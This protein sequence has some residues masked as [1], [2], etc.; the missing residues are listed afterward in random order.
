MYYMKI[1]PFISMQRSIEIISKVFN[2]SHGW[3]GLQMIWNLT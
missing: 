2:I 3:T 1:G